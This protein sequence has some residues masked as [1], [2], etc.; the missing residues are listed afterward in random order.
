MTTTA[1][2]GTPRGHASTDTA[3]RHLADAVL[4]LRAAQ[5]RLGAADLDA[6]SAALVLGLYE[7]GNRAVA[8][9]QLLTVFAADA[10]GVNR[11]DPETAAEIDALAADPRELA[12]GTA[13]VPV[14]AMC[15]R[16]APHRTTTAWIQSHLHISETEARRR[17]A[18]TRL[19]VAPA[20]PA[21]GSASEPGSALG[22]PAFPILARAA[23]GYTPPMFTD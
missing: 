22:L 12:A 19:L 21:P 13:P 5:E 23:A 15:Q 10:A 17:L 6:A 9:G 3:T 16:M 18:G 11:M 7:Q 14:E 1:P 20:P 4:A 8:F 2:T